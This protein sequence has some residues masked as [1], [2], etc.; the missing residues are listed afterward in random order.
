MIQKVHEQCKSSIATLE[1][2]N[3]PSQPLG[4]HMN[5]NSPELPTRIIQ[6]QK[7]SYTQIIWI[8]SVF[9]LQ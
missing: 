2:I 7:P 3:N 9:G 5:T 8:L 4:E 6:G 1:K